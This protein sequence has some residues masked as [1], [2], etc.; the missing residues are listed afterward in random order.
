MGRVKSFMAGLKQALNSVQ[1]T[2]KRHKKKIDQLMKQAQFDEHFCTHGVPAEYTSPYEKFRCHI[3]SA[4]EIHEA[5]V[6]AKRLTPKQEWVEFQQNLIESN[7]IA[8]NWEVLP[9]TG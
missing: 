5:H 6:R 8:G 2:Y 3:Y 9:I 7:N 4:L 1:N